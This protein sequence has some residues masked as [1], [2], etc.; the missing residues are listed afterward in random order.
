[1]RTVVAVTAPVLLA[2]PN[3]LTQSPTATAVDVVV[4]VCDSVVDLLVVILR[5]WVLGFVCFVDFEL[6]ER[7]KSWLTSVPDKVTV[8][9]L[10]AVT[11][12]VA[13][14]KFAAPGNPPRALPPLRAGK[15]P[16][17]GVSPEPEPPAPAPGLPPAPNLRR[18]RQTCRRRILLR[19]RIHWCRCPLPTPC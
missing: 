17:P 19:R 18:L 8:E 1:M 4:W 16:P 6:D 3:A 14:A 13:R 12:P 2:V 9:P 15:L 7:L 5:F 10:I 11:L